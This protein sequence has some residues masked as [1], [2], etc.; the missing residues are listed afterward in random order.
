MFSSNKSTLKRQNTDDLQ[1]SSKRQ[2]SEEDEEDDTTEGN[3]ATWIQQQLDALQVK[4]NQSY[5]LSII[6]FFIYDC[7]QVI[8]YNFQCQSKIRRFMGKTM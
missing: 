2:K 6:F 8:K 1:R 5:V 7:I 3:R 4:A